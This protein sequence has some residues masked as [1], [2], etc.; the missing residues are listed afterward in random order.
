MSRG[1]KLFS[2]H[3]KHISL[4]ADETLSLLS[5]S[6]T[7]AVT[8]V[9]VVVTGAARVRLV[10]ISSFSLFGGIMIRESILSG[11]LTGGALTGVLNFDDLAAGH[12]DGDELM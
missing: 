9:V 10:V 5:K 7:S 2:T 8:V 3:S 4:S 6:S 12:A 1:S 11:D